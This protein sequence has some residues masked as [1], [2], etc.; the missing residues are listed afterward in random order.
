[1]FYPKRIALILLAAAIVAGTV[2]SLRTLSRSLRAEEA[3]KVRLWADA[4]RSLIRADENTDMGLVLRI[5]GSNTTIPVVLSDEQGHVLE[6]RNLKEA[7]GLGLWPRGG[8]EATR[9]PD[10]G[11]TDGVPDDVAARLSRSWQSEGRS[12]LIPLEADEQAGLPA[13]RLTLCWGETLVSRRLALF[14]WVQLGLIACFALLVLY[15]LR[16][17]RRAEQNLLWAALSRETAHQ[18]GTP[19]SSLMAWVELLGEGVPPGELLPDAQRDVERLR[20]IADRFSKIGTRPRLQAAEL[21]PAL[22]SAVSYMQRRAP[23]RVSLELAPCA[24][25]LRCQ[26]CQ[27][28]LEWVIENLLRNAIDAMGPQGGHISVRLLPIGPAAAQ[29]AAPPE[30]AAGRCAIEVEDTGPG[31]PRSK[32]RHVF[33]AGYTTK[34]R[35]WG[36][37]LS[38]ARRI[39]EDFHQGRIYVKDT[40]PGQGATFRIELPLVGCEEPH[41]HVT[42]GGGANQ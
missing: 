4:A 30:P 34:A 3:T 41:G 42:D 14:P 10:A 31:V 11:R 37:G 22:Q 27:P 1:M 15:A 32:R 39:V 18:L 21:W 24:L 26:L 38:L 2:W 6:Q 35:G 36:L 40:P 28:L 19:I 8:S 17:E 9:E 23:R 13:Q 16:T 12:M 7:E 33:R 20:L 5:L 29:H 25:H